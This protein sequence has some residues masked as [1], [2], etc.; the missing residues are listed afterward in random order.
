MKLPARIYVDDALVLALSKCHMKQVLATLIETIFVIMGKPDTRVHQCP[1]ALDKW[2]ELIV[3]PRQ[4]MFGLLIGTNTL[5]VGIPPDYI[6]EV[7]DLINSTWHSHCHHF[8][9]GEAQRLTGK[10]GHLAEGAQWVFHLL[11]HLYAFIAYALAENKRL[12]ADS[13]L[14]LQSIC[15]SLRTGNFPCTAKDQVKHVNHT[16]KRAA[17]IVHH[18]KFKFNINKTMH[19]EIDFFREKLLPDSDIKW[20]TLI[21]HITPRMPAFTSFGDSCL[22]GA[23]GYSLGYW[24]HIPFP[25]E[26]MQRN[27][28]HKKDNSDGCLISINVLEFVTIITNYCALLHVITTTSATNDPYP[29]LLNVTDNASALSWT[30]GACRKSMISCRLARFF[31]SLLIG[32]PLGINSKWISTNNNKIVDIISPIK[33]QS[34][35]VFSCP[36]RPLDQQQEQLI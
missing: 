27:L 21:A 14:E 30:T 22:K 17:R 4:R 13:S 12:L 26:I 25:E 15:L 31:C 20:E 29:V 8:T 2:A 1:L 11:G 36:V 18:A 16:M 34:V 35:L 6:K 19:Q 3:A 28:L 32:S 10:L 7:L 33:M 24:W 5:T 9:V 23:G